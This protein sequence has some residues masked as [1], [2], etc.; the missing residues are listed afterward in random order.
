MVMMLYNND[1]SWNGLE[2]S[3]RELGMS[4]QMYSHGLNG[5]I[6]L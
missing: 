6:L 2:A 3:D 5:K 4:N 1:W